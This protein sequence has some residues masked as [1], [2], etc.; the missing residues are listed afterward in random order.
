MPH[1]RH[2]IAPKSVAQHA[3]HLY[4]L[5]SLVHLRFI[6]EAESDLSET[7]VTTRSIKDSNVVVYWSL[8]K[9]GCGER[10]CVGT[11]GRGG[12][13]RLRAAPNFC[14]TAVVLCLTSP[15][16]VTRTP[17]FHTSRCRYH[18]KIHPLAVDIRCIR[19]P[20]HPFSDTRPQ[21]KALISEISV[22]MLQE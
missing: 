9:H 8:G 5:F 11:H 6:D 20:L 3:K 15:C 1:F 16:C 13:C 2:I 18:S 10:C 21:S 7:I 4:P 17:A 19:R 14:V 22:H 12:Y